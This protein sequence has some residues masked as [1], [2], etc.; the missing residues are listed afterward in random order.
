MQ[1]FSMLH[2]SGV[3]SNRKRGVVEARVDL[4]WWLI[5]FLHRL[6]KFLSCL[7]AALFT[8]TI[9]LRGWC[10]AVLALVI[11]VILAFTSTNLHEF[12]PP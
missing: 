8:K 4:S 10:F 7:I 12:L 6:G 1:L 3:E 11:T 2:P 9:A 5:S